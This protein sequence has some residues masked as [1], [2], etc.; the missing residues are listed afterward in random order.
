MKEPQKVVLFLTLG[1]SDLKPEPELVESGVLPPTAY[2]PDRFNEDRHVF[3][4]LRNATRILKDKAEHLDQLTYP[5]SRPAIKFILRR[6]S[7]IDRLIFVVTDQEKNPDIEPYQLKGDSVFAADIIQQLISR[8]FPAKVKQFEKLLVER[9]PANFSYMY[10]FFNQKLAEEAYREIENHQVYLMAQGGIDGTNFSL[11]LNCI[12]KYPHLLQLAKPD[13]FLKAVVEDTPQ[14]FRINFS[15]QRILRALKKYQYLG[16]AEEAYTDTIEKLA[17]FA[18]SCLSF[19][20]DRAEDCTES[21]HQL[22]HER[23]DFY[24]LLDRYLDSL[25]GKQQLPNRLREM[26]LSAKMRLEQGNYADFL[27]KIFALSENML[28]PRVK[29]LIGVDPSYRVNPS[30]QR[31][32]STIDAHEGLSDYLIA[33]CNSY[34]KPSFFTMAG[35][36]KWFAETQDTPSDYLQFHERIVALREHRNMIAHGLDGVNRSTI[37]Q[38]LGSTEREPAEGQ[39]ALSQF[40]LD[41]DAYFEVE[42][43][44]IYDEINSHIQQML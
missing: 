21:L 30:N 34:K 24:K 5:I 7:Q 1:A 22:D 31:W 19:D 13:G 38:S 8:D 36:I 3:K 20:L 10:S 43:F 28:K 41:L 27:I 25:S 11:T 32:K 16:V 15:K 6:E 23:R 17:E 9:N 33:Y 44:G 26:Y 35:V 37:V 12:E 42:G 39:D 29:E 4:G 2:R 14:K 18:F 40:L